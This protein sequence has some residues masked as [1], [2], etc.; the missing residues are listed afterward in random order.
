[1]GLARQALD[2]TASAILAARSLIPL[3]RR[4]GLPREDP[5]LEVLIAIESET[6]TLPVGPE[7][8]QWAPEVLESRASE[9]A[10]AEAWARRVG[11]QA[12]HDITRRWHQEAH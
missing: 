4:L 6:D 3:L 10:E 2:G 1:M 12:F 11:E 7:R 8:E 9:I 5:A